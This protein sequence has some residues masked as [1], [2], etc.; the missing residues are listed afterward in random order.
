MIILMISIHQTT[1]NISSTWEPN[2]AR[3]T[4]KQNTTSNK[5]LKSNT[6]NLLPWLMK[7]KARP[8]FTQYFPF[9]IYKFRET[10]VS[11]GPIEALYP[12][13]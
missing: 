4:Y 8:F 12:A 1:F 5:I 2:T 9:I 6:R 11:S 3:R 10:S 13:R 7:K